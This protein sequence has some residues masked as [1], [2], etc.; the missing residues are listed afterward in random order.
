MLQSTT[1]RHQRFGQGAVILRAT[2]PEGLTDEDIMHRAP[3]VF[4]DEAHG[5]RSEKYSY[6]PT[7]DMLAGLRRADLVPVEVRQGGSRDA[8]K[9]GFTKHMIRMR[10]RGAVAARGGLFPEVI[11]LNSHDGT[12]SYVMTA[13]LFRMVCTN[14][15]MVGETVGEVRIPHRGDVLDRVIEG[16]YRVLSDLPRAIDGA[17]RMGAVTLTRPEQEVLARSAAL[18]RWDGTDEQP[19]ASA[20]LARR[21]ADDSGADLW[22]TFNVLQE[23]IIRGG[24]GYIHTDANQRRHARSSRPVRAIDGDRAINRALWTLAEGMRDLKAAH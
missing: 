20:L 18:L 12:S 3:S 15:L 1:I 7:R 22:S 5:S 6:I 8:E 17:E 9:R 19:T 2:S 11:A 10:H 21:R 14:G 4:A 23:N 16:A 24:V 13:G